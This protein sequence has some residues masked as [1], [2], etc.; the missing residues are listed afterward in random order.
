MQLKIFT[1]SILLTN[2]LLANDNINQTTNQE[3]SILESYNRGMYKFNNTIY[4]YVLKP[5]GQGLEYVI[6]EKGRNGINNF[7]NNA[8]FPIKFTNSILQ[9]KFDKALIESERFAINSTFGLLGFMDPAKNELDLFVSS[10]DFGQTLGYYGV[11]NGPYIILPILGQSNLR[12]TIGLIP[13]YLLNPIN[14]VDNSYYYNGLDKVNKTSLNY[15][16]IDEI[17][18]KNKDV[19]LIDKKYYNLSRNDEIKE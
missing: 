2:M 8:L 12:D 3:N 11:P 18:E 16:M 9:L 6:P 7:F 15:K 1:L 14:Y 10:E 13:D 5:L 4:T 17:N 19:Y